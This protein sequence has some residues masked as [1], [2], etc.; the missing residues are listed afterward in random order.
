MKTTPQP[1][2]YLSTREKKTSPSMQ[3]SFSTY[4]DPKQIQDIDALAALYADGFSRPPWNETW[5]LNTANGRLL[6]EFRG[7]QIAIASTQEKI[8]GLAVALPLSESLA[9]LN[10]PR[11]QSSEDRNGALLYYN[12]VVSKFFKSGHCGKVNRPGDTAS[13]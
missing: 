7:A 4:Q 2:P 5:C 1:I 10:Q 8:C 11:L 6:T 9:M 12:V 13:Y 3:L